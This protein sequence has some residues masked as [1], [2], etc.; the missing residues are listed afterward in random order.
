[1]GSRVLWRRAATA[2]AVYAATVLGVLGTIVAARSLGP[3]RFG[4]LALALAATAFFQL[5]LDST[6]EEAIVKYGYRYATAEDWGRL[7]RLFRV[8]IVVKWAGG[9]AAALAVALLAPFADAIFGTDSL[10]VPMLVAAT[11][12]LVQAPEGMAGAVLIVRGRYDLRSAFLTLSMGLRLAGVGIG[13]QLGVTEAVVGYALAQAV[14]SAAIG[15]AGAAA[16]RRFPRPDP[17]PL[18][19]DARGV[20]GFVVRSAAGT[21]LVS[22]RGTLAP[23]ALGVVAPAA[24]VAFFRAAQAPLTGFAALSAPVRLI[25]LTEQTRDA[26]QGRSDLVWRSLARFSL[27]AAAFSALVVPVGWWLMPWLVPLVFGHAYDPAVTAARLLLFA[28]AIQLVLGWTKSFPVSIGRPELRIVAHGAE[29]AVLL[30]L[31]VLLGARWE[32]AG[33][34]GAYLAATIAFGLTWLVLLARVRTQ[35][36][37]TL[38]VAPRKTAS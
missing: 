30:P 6:V 31:V 1:M 5:L 14:A 12:P 38:P 33:A 18:G 32:S 8:G 20:R 23:L 28:A 9:A 29:V 26:E 37:T 13:A 15:I 34:A 10:T 2:A 16:A 22:M 27:G 19:E 35:P 36:F 24:Q 7:R 11:I 4:L 25:M 17:V 21:G 3:E